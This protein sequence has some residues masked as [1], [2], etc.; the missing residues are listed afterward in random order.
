MFDPAVPVTVTGIFPAAVPEKTVI[1]NVAVPE[2][3]IEEVSRVRLNALWTA[4]RVTVPVYPLR[5]VTVMVALPVYPVVP[6][7]IT[8]GLGDPEILKSGP[9][10]GAKLVVI[11][12]PKPVAKS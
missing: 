12:L 3:T 8:T 1:D 2:L 11:G 10:G 7:L 5:G 9:V 4:E 6:V